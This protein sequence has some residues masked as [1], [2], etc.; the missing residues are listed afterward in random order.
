[1]QRTVFVSRYSQNPTF[2]PDI[3]FKRKRLRNSVKQ[4]SDVSIT[5]LICGVIIWISEGNVRR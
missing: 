2:I 4:W 1:M 5:A 3:H